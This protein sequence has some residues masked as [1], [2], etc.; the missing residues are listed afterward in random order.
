MPSAMAAGEIQV[1]V[2]QPYSRGIYSVAIG[3]QVTL[4]LP[5]QNAPR[6]GLFLG[7]AVKPSGE[8]DSYLLL[9]P[10]TMNV[11]YAP[12][13]SVQIVDRGLESIVDPYQQV[14]GTCTGYAIDHFLLQTELSGFRGTGALGQTLSTEEG[15]SGLLA[16]AINQYYL[17]LQHRFSI[18]GI[19]DQYG[20]RFG[21]HC[22]DKKFTTAAAA[23]DYLVHQLS[24]G[25]PVLVSFDI[26]TQM[27]TSPLD[28][29][30]IKGS[31]YS[32]L[33]RRLWTPRQIGERN[34]G[35]HS[36]V[37]AS[38]FELNGNPEAVVIDSDWSEPRIWDI[39]DYLGDRTAMDEV[40][41]ITCSP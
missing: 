8:L 7:R 33:D 4:E 12:P 11:L 31:S 40:E 34:G 29:R 6:P 20:K 28:L 41:F 35:G 15:R 21:F 30:V 5:G 25:T 36:I 23:R 18:R 39:S 22:Q 26:G 27:K 38:Y 9:D 37:A 10:R 1:R 17:V 24:F 16:D 14:G 13:S 32:H 2:Q 3:S 19:L